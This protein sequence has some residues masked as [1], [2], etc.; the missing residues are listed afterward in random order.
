MSFSYSIYFLCSVGFHFGPV[1]TQ[2]SKAACARGCSLA[3]CWVSFLCRQDTDLFVNQTSNF[4]LCYYHID[5]LVTIKASASIIFLQLKSDKTEL[6]MAG[7][8]HQPKPTWTSNPSLK[9]NP[10]SVVKNLLW[11]LIASSSFSI[12]VK[13]LRLPIIS[14]NKCALLIAHSCFY[15]PWTRL[16]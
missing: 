2:Q 14:W 8:C 13:R 3:W 4:E 9:F 10:G 5:R 6:L 11:F 1:L 16:F 15:V 12:A 7:S